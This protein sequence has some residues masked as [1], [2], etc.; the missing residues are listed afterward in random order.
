MGKAFAD[1]GM[2]LLMGLAPTVLLIIAALGKKL[3]DKIS[4]DHQLTKS[5]YANDVLSRLMLHAVMVVKEMM[6][7]AEDLKK[8]AADGQLSDEDK[9]ALKAAAL[10][11]LKGHLGLS[12]IAE[13]GEILGLDA[14]AIDRF[15][16]SHIEAAVF[17]V[18]P[19]GDSPANP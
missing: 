17:D 5:A 18:K 12:G 15:L 7:V 11:K 2:Q 10:E 4:A 3:A 14:P 13:L 19:A 16:A 8:R 1:F 6:P 9:A